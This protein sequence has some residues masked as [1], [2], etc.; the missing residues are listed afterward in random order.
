VVQAIEKDKEMQSVLN[1]V[2]ILENQ[3]DESTHAIWGKSI[4]A[5]SPTSSGGKQVMATA[6]LETIFEHYVLAEMKCTEFLCKRHSL[7]VEKTDHLEREIVEYANLGMKV[8]G[9]C[10]CCLAFLSSLLYFESLNKTSVLLFCLPYDTNY[11]LCV[12]IRILRP[13]F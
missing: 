1:N 5:P 8:G 12:A 7:M 4:S 2:R 10:E 3:L 11:I 6:E 13:I 9:V